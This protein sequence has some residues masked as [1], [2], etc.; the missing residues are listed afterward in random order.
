MNRSTRN[1]Y[2]INTLAIIGLLL[3]SALPTVSAN[4]DTTSYPVMD[5][6]LSVTLGLY[7]N[8]E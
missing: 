4:I 2:L 5:K 7:I 8:D 6:K 1:N 3:F